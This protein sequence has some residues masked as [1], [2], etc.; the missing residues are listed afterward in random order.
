MVLCVKRGNRE[1]ESSHAEELK[2]PLQLVKEPY[3]AELFF[4]VVS[5]V[6]V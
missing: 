1:P 3:L 5:L 4:G 6:M 2:M